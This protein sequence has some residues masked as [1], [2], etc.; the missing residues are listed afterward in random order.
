MTSTETNNTT[1]ATP[2]DVAEHLRTPE[3][4]AAYLDVWLEE[5]PDDAAGI[6]KALGNIARAKE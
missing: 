1:R 5:V 2:Y 3:E 4:T 6:A